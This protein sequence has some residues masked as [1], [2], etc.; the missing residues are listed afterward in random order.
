MA[1]SGIRLLRFEH[2]LI[3]LPCANSLSTLCLD[4][5]IYSVEVILVSISYYYSEGDDDNSRQTSENTHI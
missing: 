5:P 3:L 2:L 1:G 4:F